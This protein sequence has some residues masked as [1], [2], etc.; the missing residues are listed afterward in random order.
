M[1]IR[2]LLDEIGYAYDSR[3]D[4]RVYVIYV[5]PLDPPDIGNLWLERE[6]LYNRRFNHVNLF[7]ER[8]VNRQDLVELVNRLSHRIS[9]VASPGAIE[10]LIT[11][12]HIQRVVQSLREGIDELIARNNEAGQVVA[13]RAARIIDT[14]L[15]RID[16]ERASA[17]AAACAGMCVLAAF[18]ISPTASRIATTIVAAGT[19]AAIASPQL[20]A[21]VTFRAEEI[22]DELLRGLSH[23]TNPVLTA[24][25]AAIVTAIVSATTALQLP[26]IFSGIA[27]VG[28]AATA[29]YVVTREAA[30]RQLSV[31]QRAIAAPELPAIAAPEQAAVASPRTATIATQ[32]EPVM[33]RE[34]SPPADQ[35]RAAKR[36]RT[37]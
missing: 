4:N 37:D 28:A 1:S 22:R 35:E 3:N 6:F 27:A 9:T 18:T 17:G 33:E 11:P 10:I 13:A 32:T 36:N 15:N 2:A 23:P 12:S 31:I 34:R 25:S 14:S 20:A 21:H 16:P 19:A 5:R 29:S 7:R 30:R 26:V 8:G 24:G